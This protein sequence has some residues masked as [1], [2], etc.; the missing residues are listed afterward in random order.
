MELGINLLLGEYVYYTIVLPEYIGG[1]YIIG[2]SFV[3]FIIQL[4][5]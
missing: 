1:A 3:L 2:N 5:N 4:I